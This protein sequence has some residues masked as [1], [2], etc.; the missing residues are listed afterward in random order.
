MA[1]TAKQR[2]VKETQL[3][4]G[5]FTARVVGNRLRSKRPMPAKGGFPYEARTCEEWIEL[6]DAEIQEDAVQGSAKLRDAIL[7]L[8]A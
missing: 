5:R 6:T 8:A 3:A 1:R 2:A 7:A 4:M